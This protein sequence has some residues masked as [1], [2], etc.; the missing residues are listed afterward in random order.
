MK[1][2]RRFAIA[3]LTLVVATISSIALATQ[4]I[5]TCKTVSVANT[6]VPANASRL[7]WSIVTTS[8]AATIYFRADGG[9]ATVQG[10]GSAPLVGGQGYGENKGA[11]STSK[12]SAVA[13]SGSSWAC[14]VETY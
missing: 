14:V 5:T 1:R 6:I 3:V 9:T 7:G 10:A 8:G 13:V 4:S 2:S 11:A 12:I